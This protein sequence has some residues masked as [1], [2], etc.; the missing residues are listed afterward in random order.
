MNCWSRACKAE[1][2]IGE[3]RS[4][5]CCRKTSVFLSRE[6]G[7]SGHFVGRIKG[8]QRGRTSKE[9]MNVTHLIVFPKHHHVTIFQP[10]LLFIY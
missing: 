2:S 3:V 8:D 6:T 5:K 10:F 7:M 9:Q 4:L 1:P